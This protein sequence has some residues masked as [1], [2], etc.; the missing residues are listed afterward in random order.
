MQALVIKKTKWKKDLYFAVKFVWQKLTIYD[1]EVVST[2]GKLLIL[3]NI[4]DYLW[5]LA[6]RRKWH[7]GM[8]INP[9]D[10][11]SYTTKTQKAD[12]EYV[13]NE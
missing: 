4:L 1:T 6:L 7:K 8:D 2:T 11:M 9:G 3:A 10:K 13:E 12:Q 5:K